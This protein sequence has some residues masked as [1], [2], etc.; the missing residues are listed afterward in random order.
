MRAYCQLVNRASSAMPVDLYIIL[1]FVTSCRLLNDTRSRIREKISQHLP[2]CAWWKT[3]GDAAIAA[4]RVALGPGPYL[5][6]IAG[7]KAILHAVNSSPVL[8]NNAE[9]KGLIATTLA[10]DRASILT[11]YVA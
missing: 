8:K 10:M 7:Y 2:G 5:P 4:L 9:V 11:R 1:L 3:P 6:G